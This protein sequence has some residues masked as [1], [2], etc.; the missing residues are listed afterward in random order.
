MS[1]ENIAPTLAIVPARGGSKGLP[2]K[3]LRPLCGLPLI[4]HT[5]LAARESL[6]ISKLIVSTDDAEIANTART[7]GAEV[8][9]MRPPDLSSDTAGQ[10]GVAQHAVE[11]VETQ[12]RAKFAFVILL[13]P[14]APLR[15]TR[16]I[17]N[18]IK[19]LE[20]TGADSVVSF[21]RVE[22]GHPYYMYRLAGDHP[23]PLLEESLRASRR[24]DFPAIY[25]RNGAIYCV[26]RDVLVNEDSFYG[27]DTRAYIMPYDRSINI[28]TLS[29]LDLAEYLMRKRA[30]AESSGESD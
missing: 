12:L 9:F 25:V 21:Y 1:I 22:H 19:Q 28:D 4:A 6:Y 24:Q 8:P 29:D 14:T 23:E 16:D 5:I 3:N 15:T 13:Q 7:Y 20:S 26:K 11:Q 2:R 27:R 17:D 18:S 10:L 30:Q